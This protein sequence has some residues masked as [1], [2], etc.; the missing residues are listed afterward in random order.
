MRWRAGSDRTA[1][2]THMGFLDRLF[3]KKAA[4]PASSTTA[5]RSPAPP[6]ASAASAGSA[7]AADPENDPN[8]IRVFDGYG[9]EMFITRDTW[10][11]SVLPGTLQNAW[12]DH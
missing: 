10:R 7:P 11:T 8:L 5:S 3:G 9:R 4:P 1:R 2:G 6:A 12:N